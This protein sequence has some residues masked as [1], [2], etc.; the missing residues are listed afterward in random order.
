MNRKG[1]PCIF[2]GTFIWCVN[3]AELSCLHGRVFVN[4]L[5]Q[6]AK[7]V[8]YAGPSTNNEEL[9]RQLGWKFEDIAI[10]EARENEFFFPGFIGAWHECRQY[11]FEADKPQTHIFMPLSFPMLASSARQHYLTGSRDTRTPWKHHSLI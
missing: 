10:F 8:K 6:I 1:Q 11:F 4:E 5:G 9:I 3:L 7:V 2:V